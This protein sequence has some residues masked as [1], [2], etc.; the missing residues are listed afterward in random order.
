MTLIPPTLAALPALVTLAI[1]AGRFMSSLAREAR[2]ITVVW[3][4][5]RGTQP[6]QRAEIIR[7]FASQQRQGVLNHDSTKRLAD[8][9]TRR[10]R[11]Q[12]ARK[13]EV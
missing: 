8:A 2:I 10:P 11:R 5:L 6:S 1:T 3:L 9:E 7:A 12:A 4:A 13:S